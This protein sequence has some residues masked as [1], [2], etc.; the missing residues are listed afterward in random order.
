[1]DVPNVNIAVSIIRV[2]HKKD[3]L[4]NLRSTPTT[5]DKGEDVPVFLFEKIFTYGELG[6]F[7]IKI[8]DTSQG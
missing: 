5:E 1:M 7:L 2:G 8:G 6:I 3:I 4:V